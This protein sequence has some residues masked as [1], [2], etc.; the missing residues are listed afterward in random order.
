LEIER[1]VGFAGRP[2][3]RLLGVGDLPVHPRLVAVRVKKPVP[4][5]WMSPNSILNPCG[6]WVPDPRWN[7][8]ARACGGNQTPLP[9]INRNEV[10]PHFA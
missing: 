6:I 3:K 2:P 5:P 1:V 9:Y 10:L 7:F 4:S 8:R